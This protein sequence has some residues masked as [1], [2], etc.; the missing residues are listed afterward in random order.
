MGLGILISALW[1]CVRICCPGTFYFLRRFATLYF[2]PGAGKK[3][4]KSTPI[5]RPWPKFINLTRGITGKN[6]ICFLT[7]PM[8]PAWPVCWF[9][10]CPH[11]RICHRKPESGPNPCLSSCLTSERLLLELWYQGPAS[12]KKCS[13]SPSSLISCDLSNFYFPLLPSPHVSPLWLVK[14][15]FALWGPLE[16]WSENLVTVRSDWARLTLLS[17]PAN[18]G[19]SAA[20]FLHIHT[21]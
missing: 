10:L 20:R 8:G 6:N 13:L 7:Y 4:L 3:P 1:L 11:P 9:S 18:A 19:C 12:G 14:M 21:S 16:S 15:P 2:C 5:L 17:L